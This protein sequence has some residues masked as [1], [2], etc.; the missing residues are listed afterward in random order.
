M[1]PPP[2]EPS[3]NDTFLLSRSLLVIVW[4]DGRRET[5]G[6]DQDT[7][8]IGRGERQNDLALPDEFTSISRQ[9]LE[10]QR[11]DSGYEIRDLGSANGVF[12]NGKRIDTRAALQ[13]GDEITLGISNKGEQVRL[14]FSTGAA[15]LQAE[16][17]QMSETEAPASGETGQDRTPDNLPYLVIRWNTGE[18]G[19]FPLQKTSTLI[20]RD[21][22]ADLNLSSTLRFVSKRH[23]EI[24][25]TGRGYEIID[26][27]STNGTWVNGRLLPPNQ[28]S[29]LTDGAIIRIGDE[30]FGASVGLMFR[31]PEDGQ[32]EDL[33]VASAGAQPT[34]I[35]PELE[36]SIGRSADCDIVLDSPIVSRR[37]ARVHTLGEASWI[38]DLKSTNGTY[39]NHLP[40]SRAELTEGDRI[41]IGPHV[42]VYSDGK[43][44]QYQSLGM[45]L[46]VRGLSQS[47]KKREGPLQ[48]LHGISMTVMPR[49]F[50]AIV[51]GSG[52]GKSTLMNALIG[53]RPGDGE[54]RLNGH[55]LYE[56]YEHFRSQIGFVPQSDILHA[57][58]TVEA[59]LQYTASL[60]LPP[61]SSPAERDKAISGVLETVS[62]NTETI[63]A[64]RISDLSG[65]QR[66]RVSIAAE[67][68]ADPKLIFLDEATSGLDPGL[69]KKMMFTL[70]RMAD[71]GRTV[72]L[73]TH[74]TDNI[75]QADHVLFLA[76]GRQ[77][78]FGPPSE[79][80]DFFAVEDFADIYE[81]IQYRGEAWQE[82]FQQKKPEHY[83]QLVIRRQETMPAV[84]SRELPKIRFGV[85]NFF[86]QFSVFTRRTLRVLRS[87]WF[88]LTL[89]LLLFPLTGLLQLV[90]F[91]ADVL[92]GD[93]AILAD[94]AAAAKSLTENYIPFG[95]LNTFIF[96][97]GLEA[98]LVGMYVPS[99][100]L[101]RDR[102][103]YLR[104]RMIFLRIP[105]YLISKVF[106]F[107]V[108]AALQSFLYLVV[109]SIGVDFPEN[110][111]YLPA[112]FEL[113]ITLFLTVG[114]A[115]SLGFVVSALSKS[116]DMA[117]YVLVL[118]LFFQF[119]FGGMVF[120]LRQNPAEPLSYLTTTRWSLTAIA[121]TVD[122]E[123]LVEATVLCNNPPDNPLT[124][125]DESATVL[126]FNFPEATEDITLPFGDEWL[127]RSW[128]I[129][130]LIGLTGM[131]TTG[132]LVKRL[133]RI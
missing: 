36:I 80:L 17:D 86:R 66:K 1:Q 65:G 108:F 107:T 27:E 68:L 116:S 54:V 6:L 61:D 81:Q 24:R 67:L 15:A 131:L 89:M 113:F 26:L 79:A 87:D 111:L 53:F 59:A 21:I 50:V 3:Q 16:A 11:V 99:N 94:P 74:A 119:F 96:V 91:N 14:I 42:L 133:D 101:I 102:L 51:G 41:T 33:E 19:H 45:R 90:I 43:L 10:L 37:H 31:S 69:E 46:D 49:E 128:G 78:Y 30:R 60:R 124:A 23:A 35:I 29:P 47:V 126:C 32:P 62:M 127:L 123:R 18:T 97:M 88:T 130:I 13:D 22:R 4:P 117:I 75:R 25:R 39:V 125:E 129:L 58:L 112:A 12:V 7:V 38:E 82:V 57:S 70:R 122:I 103:V 52:A 114:A 71:E 84:S 100:E 98:V 132:V 56:E 63:R 85:R 9:H 34:Q 118:L 92:I 83:Q 48:I 104:E 105:P 40:I 44:S 95:D 73:I 55:D 64:N 77:V 76:Q 20:G 5:Y 110:G 8:R 115:M 109:L 120:D 106:V 93:P 121:V 72:I 2:N 28:A